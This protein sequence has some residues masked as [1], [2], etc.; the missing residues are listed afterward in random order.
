[1][2][3]LQKKDKRFLAR[4]KMFHF[5]RM[6][7]KNEGTFK[8]KRLEYFLFRLNPTVCLLEKFIFVFHDYLATNV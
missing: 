6:K 7:N 4:K 3:E 8:A 5:T 1:M 2:I